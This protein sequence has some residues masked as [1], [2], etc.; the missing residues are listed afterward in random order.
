MKIE[1]RGN[2]VFIS[3][4][5]LTIFLNRTKEGYTIKSTE[6]LQNGDWRESGFMRVSSEDFKKF[7]DLIGELAR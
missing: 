3:H 2:S 4:S 5:G 6:R 7:A 1:K